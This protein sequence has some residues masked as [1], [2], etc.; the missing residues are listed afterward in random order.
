MPIYKGTDEITSGKLYKGATNIEDGYKGTSPFYTNTREIT[1]LSWQSAANYPWDGTN[2]TRVLVVTGDAG[3]TYTIAGNTTTAPGGT[4]TIPVGGSN[5]HNITGQ[6]NPGTYGSASIENTSSYAN[7]LYYIT[8][9]PTSVPASTTIQLRTALGFYITS[10]GASSS[11]RTVGI[12]ITPTGSS[13]MASGVSPTLNI[14]QNGETVSNLPSTNFGGTLT[15]ATGY[16]GPTTNWVPVNTSSAPPNVAGWNQCTSQ[17]CSGQS[18]TFDWLTCGDTVNC[19]P[20]NAYINS[21]VTMPSVPGTYTVSFQVLFNNQVIWT[22]S[23]G[24][25]ITIT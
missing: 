4:F 13:T 9:Y 11:S 18:G 1:S 8:N 17:G 10:N 3:A 19:Y 12:T 25:S 6:D 24:T 5:N 7:G 14:T 2:Y 20:N 23:Q 22:N 15:S 21:S 16:S